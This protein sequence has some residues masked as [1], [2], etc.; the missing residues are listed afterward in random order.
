MHLLVRDSAGQIFEGVLLAAGAYSLRIVFQGF[1][2]TAELRLAD[3]RW[4]FDDGKTA[5]FE[6]LITQSEWSNF[7]RTIHPR[8]QSVGATASF[9]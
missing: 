9:I 1:K 2:D 3:G 8:A 5:E 7:C 4:M 6:S